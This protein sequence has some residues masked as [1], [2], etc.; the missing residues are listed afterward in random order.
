MSLLSLVGD[1]IVVYHTILQCKGGEM[2]PKATIDVR[3]TMV[4]AYLDDVCLYHKMRG[5]SHDTCA[6]CDDVMTLVVLLPA[7]IYL[8]LLIVV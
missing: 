5:L 8:T 3:T 1:L 2:Q 7:H 4:G 6:A